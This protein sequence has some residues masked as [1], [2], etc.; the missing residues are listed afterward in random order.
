MDYFS[1]DQ[2]KKY[3]LMN[4]SVFDLF[5]LFDYL[6]FKKLKVINLQTVLFGARQKI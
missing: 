4:F 3:I 2:A 6:N 5:N 1:S